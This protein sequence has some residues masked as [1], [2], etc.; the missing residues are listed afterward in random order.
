MALARQ[1]ALVLQRVESDAKMAGRAV[2]DVLR[3]GLRV[4]V[5]S[6]GYNFYLEE[7]G[8]FPGMNLACEVVLES[9][10]EFYDR[11][12]AGVAAEEGAFGRSARACANPRT[13]APAATAASA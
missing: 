7:D 8:P 2:P 10:L 6:K 11:I 1:K 9:C 13:W 3:D 12:H 4:E 5:R